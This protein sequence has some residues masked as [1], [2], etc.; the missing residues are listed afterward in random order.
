ML[1]NQCTSTN[2]SEENHTMTTIYRWNPIREM[3]AME[4]AMDRFFEANRR[5]PRTAAAY[6][7]PLDAYETDQAYVVFAALPGIN[8]ADIQVHFEDDTLTISGEVPQPTFEE[9]VN[10]RARLTERTYGKFSRSIRVAQPVDTDQVEAAYDNGLLKLTLPKTTAA[11]PR[12]I[13]VRVTAS[14]N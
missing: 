3:N 8:P 13:P 12:Q 2:Q 1:V 4:Q 9:G 6:S 7:L 11:Q 10:A 14:A 5:S